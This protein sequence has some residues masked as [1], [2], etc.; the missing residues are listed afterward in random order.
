MTKTTVYLPDDLKRD[1]ARMA[2]ESGRSEADLIRE[3]I[4]TLTRTSAR[5]RPRGALFASGDS[6]LA[7]RTEDALGGFGD[8]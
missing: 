5:P 2:T 3:A 1:L 6:T 7:E 4:R 8:S